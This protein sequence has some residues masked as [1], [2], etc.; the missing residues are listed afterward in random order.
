[1]ALNPLAPSNNGF[2]NLNLKSGL[3]EM[4][5][6]LN[7]AANNIE[8]LQPKALE[9]NFENTVR[10]QVKATNPKQD[11]SSETMRARLAEIK[12]LGAA[13][14]KYFSPGVLSNYLTSTHAFLSDLQENSFS[15]QNDE[16]GLFENLNIINDELVTISDEFFN[17]QRDE[18]K[19]IASLDLIE[20]LLV[21]ITA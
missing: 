18:L 5:Q 13:V 11:F 20:G 12:Q 4:T 7:I 10:D 8:A 19:I 2:N 14:K 9:S 16:D 1:M 15:G 21:D 17:E 3:S 6:R